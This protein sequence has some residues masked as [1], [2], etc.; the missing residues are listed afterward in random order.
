[1]TTQGRG[2]VIGDV[3]VLDL[4]KVTEETVGG[5]RSIG[6]VGVVFFS[7]ETAPLVAR[8]SIGDV[9]AMIE[10]PADAKMVN[11]QFTLTRES[12]KNL[13]S[14]LHLVVNG[15]LIVAPDVELADVENNLGGIYLNGLI[16]YPEPLAGAVQSKIVTINGRSSAYRLGERLVFA[17]RRTTIDESYLRSLEDGTDLVIVGRGFLPKVVP[18]ELLRQKIRTLQVY[19]RIRL[20]EENAQTVM[21]LMGDSLRGARITVIPAGHALVDGPL[22]LDSAVLASLP[23]RALYCTDY[24]VIAADVEAD[25]LDASLDSIVAQRALI[26]PASLKGVAARKCNLLETRAVFYEGELWLVENE[27]ELVPLRFEFMEG[28]ATLV[29]MGELFI[30]PDV[31]P[32]VIAERLS[33]VHNFGEIRCTRPQMGAI[34]ARLGI[35]E[36]ELQESAARSADAALLE[37]LGMGDEELAGPSAEQ[38]ATRGGDAGYLAL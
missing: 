7:R 9:G 28:R 38:S 12:L 1:M 15:Q 3:G 29:N 8:L 35:N 10:A 24:V 13:A 33:K 30:A 6:S 36:G 20:H 27:L 18:D 25:A 32:R 31:E 19:D 11:G 4:R 21:A 2:R 14:P 37:R 16:V 34:Q 17:V 22:T 5:I 26:C 23:S